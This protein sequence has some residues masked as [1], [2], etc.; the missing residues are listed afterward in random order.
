MVDIKGLRSSVKTVEPYIPG[1]T[2]CEVQREYRLSK[3]IKLGSNENPYGPFP[4][5]LAAMQ[6]E[7]TSLYMYPD[8]DFNEI[9]SAIAGKFGIDDAYISIA[10]GAGGMLQ[11]LAKT[12]IDEG[13]EVL[14]P[15]QTYG[16]YKEISKL[17]G[18]II[19][20]IP[21]DD[22]FTIDLEAIQRAITSKTKLI[23]LCNPNNPTGTVFDGAA[24]QRLLNMLPEHAWVVL[25]E[26]YAEFAA[27][28]LLPDSIKDI[29]AGKNVIVVRTFSKAY[30]LAGAR[31]GYAIARPD[32]IT[33]IDTVAEPFN[34]NRIGIAGA[35]ATL[36]E[37]Q[38]PYKISLQQIIKDRQMV[39]EALK[40]M[41]FQVSNS[42]TNFVFFHTP[43]NAQALSGELMK[44]GIIVRPC[45]AWNYPTAIR[46]TVGTSEEMIKFLKLFQSILERKKAI[47]REA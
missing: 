8:S 25:D 12:F 20:E 26:A 22:S 38:V 24:Y 39:S 37:D 28:H 42:H 3:V 15:A 11:T 5:A 40:E 36:K 19:K 45:T 13:D 17:M 30:G 21:L 47:R 18:G 34:A 31:I 16:L 23:W 4:S 14:M 41:D 46:I 6:K 44:K 27:S 2:I 33:A 35:I 10:H 9:K 1:K 43:Y 7:L 32:M 29:R